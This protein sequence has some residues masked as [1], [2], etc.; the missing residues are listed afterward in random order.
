MPYTINA[1]DL[2][3]LLRKTNMPVVQSPEIKKWLE[4]AHNRLVSGEPLFNAAA[5]YNLQ[6]LKNALA[7]KNVNLNWIDRGWPIVVWLVKTIERASP[8]RSNKFIKLVLLAGANPNAKNQHGE[9]ALALAS[10]YPVERANSLIQMLLEAKADPNV[11]GGGHPVPL[12]IVSNSGNIEGVKLL[13]AH[14]ANPE[15]PAL[16]EKRARDFAQERGHAEIVKLLDEA[17]EKWKAKAK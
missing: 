16:N 15:I 12:I 3:N 2:V 8:E 11:S 13:L 17:A 7:D 10:Y 9:T 4:V 1:I 14:G 5:N 6:E